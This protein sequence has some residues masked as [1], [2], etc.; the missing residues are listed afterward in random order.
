ME[1]AADVR[2]AVGAG[3]TE[4]VAEMATTWTGVWRDTRSLRPSW[5]VEF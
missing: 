1:V 5:P 4:T 2:K 3:V